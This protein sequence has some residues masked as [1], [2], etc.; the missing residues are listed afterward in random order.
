MKKDDY[1]ATNVDEID[2][3]ATIKENFDR[4]T[5][6]LKETIEAYRKNHKS[7]PKVTVANFKD[8]C[9]I[10]LTNFNPSDPKIKEEDIVKI[11]SGEPQLKQY[12]T[13]TITMKNGNTATWDKGEWSDYRYDGKC[14]V[15]IL[16]DAWIGF[17]N[18]DEVYTIV[19]E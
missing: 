6:Y 9:G 11:T 14:F 3:E 7:G 13:I 5:N 1:I 15:V 12:E 19:V 18:I 17:Y 4:I 10:V 2:F 8:D 16:N